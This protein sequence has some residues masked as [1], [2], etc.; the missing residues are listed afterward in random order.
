MSWWRTCRAPSTGGSYHTDASSQ[1]SRPV[2]R[3]AVLDVL[4]LPWPS[5]PSRSGSCS[6]AG[7]VG[8]PFTP[9]YSTPNPGSPLRVLSW[10]RCPR[11]R[12]AGGSLHTG[13]ILKALSAGGVSGF[14]PT[15]SLPSSYRRV[16]LRPRLRSPSQTCRIPETPKLHKTRLS[17]IDSL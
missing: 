4:A 11:A 1:R 13:A 8:F 7:A 15:G 16:G 17:P 12:A 6:L 10:S 9:G 3:P 14:L 2:P 5:R